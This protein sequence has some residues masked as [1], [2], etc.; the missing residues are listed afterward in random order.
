MATTTR[1]RQTSADVTNTTKRANAQARKL[2]AAAKK[3]QS[4][5][6]DYRVCACGCERETGSTWAPGHDQ[7]HKGVLLRAFDANNGAESEAAATELVEKWGW[8]IRP[9]LAERRATAERKAAKKVADAEARA[10]EKAAAK[11]A[12]ATKAEATDDEAAS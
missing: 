6:A 1:R 7:R 9:I 8:T 4:A 11:E 3:G 10:K 5:Q 2:A 12:K